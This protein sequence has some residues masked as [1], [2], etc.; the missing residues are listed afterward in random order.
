MDI[1]LYPDPRLRRRNKPVT[2]FGP[3]LER[4]AREMF[5]VMYRTRGVGLAAP[6][7]GVNLRFL[8]YNHT[9]EA[10]RPEEE[11]ILCN[12]RVTWRSRETEMGEEGCLSFP[13]IYA[14]V[15]RPVAVRVEAR[16]AAGEET[17]LELEGF[18]A[19]VFLHELDHLDGILFIDRMTKS[20][21][22]RLRGAL[23]DLEA[24][25][26]GSRAGT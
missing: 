15:R 26:A 23:A 11:R 9:G 4:L 12:P 13:E 14:P 8:V 19:R 5:A 17:R 21:R 10:E 7:V 24:R 3:E 6:Q 20:D 25:F 1:L 2:E 22:V 18:A 16:D